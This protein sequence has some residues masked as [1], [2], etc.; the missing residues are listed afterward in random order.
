MDGRLV[1]LGSLFGGDRVFDIPVFQRSYAW[2]EKNLQ[3]LWEDLEYLDDSKQHYFGTVLLKDSGKVAETDFETLTRFDVIDGQ[4]R[5]TT[6]SILLGEIISQLEVSKT[7]SEG[8]IANLREKYLR[9]DSYYRLNPPGSEP[10]SDGD[11]FH[12]YVV[13]GEYAENKAGTRSQRRIVAAR[14]FFRKRISNETKCPTS[15]VEPT[16]FLRQ[17]MRKVSNLQLIE[18]QV[19][20]DAD[21]IRI[22]E[23]VNDRG[24]PLS[25]LEKIKSFLMHVSYLAV[26]GEHSVAV[27][28]RELNGRF[29][30]M[31]KSFEQASEEKRLEHSRLTEDRILRYHYMNYVSPWDDASAVDGLKA[32]IRNGLNGNEKEESADYSLGYATDLERTFFG[33][34]DMA[35]LSDEHEKGERLSKIFLTG[36]TGNILPLM[37]ASWLKFGDGDGRIERI[38]RLLEAFTIRVYLVGRRRSNTGA[39]KF[40]GMAHRVHKGNL[41]YEGLIS[42]LREVNFFYQSDGGFETDLRHEDFYVRHKPNDVKYLLSEY[43]INLRQKGDVKLALDTQRQLLTPEYQVEHIWA[44][45]PEDW[46]A[47]C[48]ERREQHG[49]NKHKMGNLT[50]ASRSWNSS[51]GNKPFHEKR[52]QAEDSPSYANSDLRVQRVLAGLCEWNPKTIE[53]RED[54]LVAFALE[55]WAIC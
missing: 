37:L 11:F 8:S 32:R 19:E 39:S 46:E 18:Y 25:N 35:S 45:H 40:N 51:M 6:I 47:M 54:K 30:N 1:S 13:E 55:R 5:L 2:E 10:G 4:Q 53:A 43:E 50:I 33:I 29:A 34:K 14:K 44:Q 38:L 49:E 24:R 42:E 27:R 17:L 3:D 31:Y 36:R 41:D 16:E 20:T 48:Q 52:L 28:L 21:A 23:T 22:F 7:G 9:Y 12:R 15:D 26:E